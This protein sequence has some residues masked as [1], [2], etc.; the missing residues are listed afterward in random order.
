M[1]KCP[2]SVEPKHYICLST[3]R[4]RSACTFGEVSSW[5]CVCRVLVLRYPLFVYGDNTAPLV[6]LGNRPLG[7]GDHAPGLVMIKVVGQ[8][9]PFNSSFCVLAG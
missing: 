7:V 5:C 3:A 9:C 8:L 6:S 4:E 1:C 2:C